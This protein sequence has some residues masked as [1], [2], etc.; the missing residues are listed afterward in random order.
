MLFRSDPGTWLHA[1]HHLSG[2]AVARGSWTVMMQ[3]AAAALAIGDIGHQWLP[4]SVPPKTATKRPDDLRRD[5][6][7]ALP[8]AAPVSRNAAGSLRELPRNSVETVAQRR[9]LAVA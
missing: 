1:V 2:R 7:I 3:R 4:I 9:V 8:Y 6:V 5:A